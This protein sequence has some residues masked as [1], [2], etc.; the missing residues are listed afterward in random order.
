MSRIRGRGVGSSLTIRPRGKFRLLGEWG[1]FGSGFLEVLNSI[2]WGRTP[3]N[4]PGLE[5]LEH[6][7]SE[8][9]S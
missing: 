6:G 2:D 3:I 9:W 1:E 7:Q 5:W 8:P 4:Y